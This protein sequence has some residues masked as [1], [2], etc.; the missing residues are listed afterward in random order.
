[1]EYIIDRFEGGK[2]VLEEDEGKF[3]EVDKALL[4][5]NA[6][7]GD[8]LIFENGKY[9]LNKEKSAKL[10]EDIDNLMDELFD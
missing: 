8:C 4:P 5:E 3:K 10:K 6:Q 7:E 9:T 2:A 1:M